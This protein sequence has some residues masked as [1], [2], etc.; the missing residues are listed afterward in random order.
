[1]WTMNLLVAADDRTGA[2]ETAAELADHGTG[3]VPVRVWPTD[4]VSG[5]VDLDSRRVP[6]GE[7]RHRAG[8]LR[9]DGPAAHKIDST[10]RGNWAHEL[11][12]RHESSRRPVLVVPALPELGR[13]C[14]GGVVL[15]HGEP[16]AAGRP[17]DLLARAGAADVVNLVTL[18]AVVS[19]LSDPRGIAIADAADTE[20]VR[21]IAAAW[22]RSPAPLLAGTSAVIG[23]TVGCEARLPYG[24]PPVDGAVLVACGSLH[25]VARGQVAVAEQRG[26]MVT[27]VADDRAKAALSA[28]EPVIL[29]TELPTGDVTEPMAVAAASALAR[30]VATLADGIHVGALVLIGGDTA[31]AVLG[32]A[33]MLVQGSIAPGTAWATVEGLD[34]PVISRS[35]GFGPPNA[36]V[37][38]LWEDLR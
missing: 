11:V 26:V 31:A 4:M 35:G 15:A 3:P 19:W 24:R 6:A 23:S 32:D 9:T 18:D 33:E 25:P 14:V 34:P 7:A 28:G 12:A 30:G 5:V 38:L 27:D 1:M 20:A 10:L 29:H 16:V 2:L 37:D 13:T 36:L 17:V 21:A 8:T 22:S